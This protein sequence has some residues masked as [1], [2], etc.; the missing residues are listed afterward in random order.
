MAVGRSA[1]S[2][3]ALMVRT[4]FIA[5]NRDWPTGKQRLA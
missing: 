4:A 1:G 3:K 2:D 5:L